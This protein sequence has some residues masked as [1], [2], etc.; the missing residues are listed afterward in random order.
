[1]K[2]SFFLAAVLAIGTLVSVSAQSVQLPQPSPAASVSLVAGITEIKIDYSSPAVKGREIYGNLVPMG[3][4]WRTGA[5]SATSISFST[6]VMID[7]KPVK[8]G[9]YAIFTIPNQN[10]WTVIL[11]SNEGQW[12]S[13][14]Y[15]KELDVLRFTV[16]PKKL[17]TARERLVFSLDHISDNEAHVVFGWEKQGFRFPVKLETN[18]LVLAGINKF[19]HF[20]DASWYANANSAIYLAK[21]KTDLSRALLLADLSVSQSKHFYSR[22]AKAKV[23]EAMGDVPGAIAAA[24]E[25]KAIG[26]KEP[27]S[28]FDAYKDQI[29][30]ALSEWAAIKP[31]KKKK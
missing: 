12:G 14:N 13:T 15:K 20:D 18:K 4:V 28:F 23:L 7:G 16:A 29:D 27:S 2:K 11:N 31:A 8:A 17:S 22:W 10:E 9:K 21:E 1:M 5:N 3:E 26:T 19:Y 25:A 6:D 30:A 24:T